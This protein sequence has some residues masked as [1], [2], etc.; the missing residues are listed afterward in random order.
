MRLITILLF[1]FITSC[2]NQHHD[3]LSYGNDL[4][5]QRF[6]ELDQINTSNIDQLDLAW[7]IQTG[8]K[9][10]FQATPLVKNGVMYISLP[11]NDVIAV[12]A[13]TGQEIWRYEHDRN[14]D[15]PMCCGPANRGLG[16]QGNQLFM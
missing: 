7:Q 15:W 5:N 6:S 14:K 16:L 4:F 1:L 11:F 2:S 8:T 12:N 13:K 3:W 9:S 10:S